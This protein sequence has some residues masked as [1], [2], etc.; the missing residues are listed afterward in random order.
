MIVPRSL[1][2]LAVGA[3]AGYLFAVRPWHLR[4]GADDREVHGGMAGDDLV[5]VPQYQATR[6]I[7]IDAPP[8]SVWAWLIQLG[9]YTPGHGHTHT[10]PSERPR[11][12]EWPGATDQSGPAA[13]PGTQGPE[14]AGQGPEAAAQG[15]ETAG[16]GPDAAQQGQEA[17]GQGPGA[18]Q[19]GPAAG[20]QGPEGGQQT[21]GQQTA[22]RQGFK[23]GD[24]LSG[25][26]DGAGF[27]VEEADPPHTLVLAMR[28]PDA[29]TTC[30][31]A[32]RDLDG[33]TRMVVRVRIR[34]TPG[35]R[36]TT[37]LA[38]MDVGDFLA[39]RR[40]MLTIKERAENLPH[41]A[42]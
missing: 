20:P 23:V 22:G 12:S 31:I 18:A 37:Y 30:S 7:T 2:R 10:G 26:P 5:R 35:L 9:A 3:A 21:A 1:F 15:P 36:G 29:T 19:Q 4:W 40:Q 38:T 34:A 6:A 16:Q 27:V 24:V 8:A 14:A 13:S 25:A 32:L 33:R 17:T 41:S 39:M 42:G 28:G 11:S